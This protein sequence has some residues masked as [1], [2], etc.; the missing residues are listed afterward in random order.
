MNEFI[1]R[2][3]KITTWRY[4]LLNPGRNEV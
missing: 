2:L 4:F 1:Y 3:S